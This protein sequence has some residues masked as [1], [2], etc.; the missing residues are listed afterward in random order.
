MRKALPSAFVSFASARICE[1]AKQVLKE[2]DEIGIYVGVGNE[3]ETFELI[4]WCLLEGKHVY[5]PKVHGDTMD[6]YAVTS[7]KELKKGSFGLLEPSGKEAV[8]PQKLTHMVMPLVAFNEAC[9]RI[10]QGKGYYD[11]YLKKCH[12]FTM[13]LAYECQ[14]AEF[15]TESHDIDMQLVIT[16]EN[17]YKKSI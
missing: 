14:K 10:G 16:E 15:S 12:C 2:A 17:R 9:Q 13:G 1:Q 5:C 11:K 7:L 8:E 4:R 3:V 6:F